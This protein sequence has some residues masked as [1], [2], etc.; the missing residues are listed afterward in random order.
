MIR[1]VDDVTIRPDF[2]KPDVPYQILRIS[3]AIEKKDLYTTLSFQGLRR[4]FKDSTIRRRMGVS[5]YD[6][7]FDIHPMF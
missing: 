3:S 6:K 1:S 7:F 4:L 5:L 2:S